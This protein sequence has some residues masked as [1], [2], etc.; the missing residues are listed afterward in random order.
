MSIVES[1]SNHLG[2]S[3]FYIGLRLRKS[4]VEVAGTIA[5][6]MCLKK[7]SHDYSGEEF[8][9]NRMKG[10]ERLPNITNPLIHIGLPKQIR[11]K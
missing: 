9:C 11:I 5:R 3:S 4:P 8:L 6:E 7:C 2:C 10:H 1:V